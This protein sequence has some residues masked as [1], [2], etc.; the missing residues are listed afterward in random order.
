MFEK[1]SLKWNDFQEN[2]CT[3]FG[4]LRENTAFADV[5]LV[6]EGGQQIEAH[7]FVLA[8]SSPFFKQLFSQNKHSHPLVF[9][10]GVKSDDL[11]AIVDFLYLGEANIYENNLEAFLNIAEELRLKGLNR[12]V[13]DSFNNINTDPVPKSSPLSK[14][15]Q[16]EK[17]N[18]MK[19]ETKI[20]KYNNENKVNSLRTLALPKQDIAEQFQ[21]LDESVAILIQSKILRID[22]T[23]ACA[24]CSYTTINRTHLSEHIESKHVSSGHTCKY[25]QK[26][27]PSRNALRTHMNKYHKI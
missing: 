10:R 25:C 19:N 4:S 2:V 14:T 22:N 12:R 23:W 3:S 9:M 16:T 8:S 26:F 15:I 24:D 27:V 7:K 17:D 13:D 18:T 20:T 11:D 1:F 21:D 5:T 6:C